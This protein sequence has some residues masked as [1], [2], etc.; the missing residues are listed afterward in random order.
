M[1]YNPYYFAKKNGE[2]VIAKLNI[3][4]ITLLQTTVKGRKGCDGIRHVLSSSGLLKPCIYCVRASL[5]MF[6]MFG[7]K[8]FLDGIVLPNVNIL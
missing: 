1:K 8:C 3:T 7:K 2:A 4:R 6:F 5:Y